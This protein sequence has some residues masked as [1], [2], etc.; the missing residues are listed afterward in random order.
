M[1]KGING[2]NQSL[3]KQ[4][5]SPGWTANQGDRPLFAGG[6]SL[7]KKGW[8]Q[9]KGVKQKNRSAAFQLIAKERARRKAQGSKKLGGS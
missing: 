4:M 2:M 6:R 9:Y 7:S 1:A 5:E 3:W 8:K